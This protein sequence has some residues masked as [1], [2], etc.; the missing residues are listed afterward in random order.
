MISFDLGDARQVK[1]PRAGARR[2]RSSVLLLGLGLL[3][4]CRQPAASLSPGASDNPDAPVTAETCRSADA[5]EGA[6]V[7]YSPELAG[8]VVTLRRP[9][10]MRHR[11]MSDTERQRRIAWLRT[12]QRVRSLRLWT[13][14]IPLPDLREFPE[15]RRL[16]F[17]GA[18]GTDLRELAGLRR[19]EHLELQLE[20]DGCPN[21]RILEHIPQLRELSLVGGDCET[22]APLASL[23]EL[24]RLALIGVKTRDL[25]FLRELPQLHE[26]HLDHNR[27]V[28]A[29]I[30][31]PAL[32]SL[33]TS[34]TGPDGENPLDLADIAGLERLENL[35]LFGVG[36]VEHP[37]LLAKCVRLRRLTIQEYNAPS[38]LAYAHG[39]AT[40][41]YLD[42]SRSIEVGA[43]QTPLGPIKNIPGLRHLVLRDLT[44]PPLLRWLCDDSA[45]ERLELIRSRPP[46]AEEA[47]VALRACR[48]DLEVVLV[49]PRE[50]AERRLG[51]RSCLGCLTDPSHPRASPP[52]TAARS[53]PA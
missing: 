12:L 38:L 11:S 28:D 47:L 19:L 37:E 9:E 34:T 26:L 45:L 39:M 4:G 17:V 43:N 16:D 50:L 41:M 15:L 44:L 51:G 7:V 3:A 53:P 42:L 27:L 2:R 33:E 46:E 22:L 32:L 21:L 5:P 14:D 36:E 6:E 8:C 23:R 29:R 48:P 40:L 13:S 24:R 31:A 52:K 30:E 20:G 1:L 18:A 35:S 49:D 10:S 25:G